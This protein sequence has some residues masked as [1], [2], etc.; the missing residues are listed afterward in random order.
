MLQDG[1]VREASEWPVWVDG[2]G[3]V[4]GLFGEVDADMGHVGVHSML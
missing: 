4:E 3:G 1:K 2:D